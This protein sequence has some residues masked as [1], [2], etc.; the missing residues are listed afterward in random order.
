MSVL[1]KEW[2]IKNSSPNKTALEKVLENRDSLADG[3][4]EILHDPYLFEDMEFSVERINK[5]IKDKERIIVFGDYD[6]DG[7][8]GTAILVHVLGRLGAQ[9]SY[10]LPNRLED[11]YGFT[12]KFIPEF[13]DAGVSLLITTDC[14][15]SCADTITEAK[16]KG[17]ETIITDH[18]TVPEKFP[19]DAIAILH[20][21]SEKTAYPYRELTGAGV[22]L[23]L[24]QA[25]I[26]DLPEK[27]ELTASL[28]DL[29]TMGTIADLG[30]LTGE[31]RAIVK[32]GL[33]NLRTTSWVGIKKLMEIS[34]VPENSEIDAQTIGFRLAPR[35]NAA[36]RIGDPYVALSLILQEE[37]GEKLN[38]LGQK[39]ESL[40]VQ[41]QE[42]MQEAIDMVEIEL[43]GG[44]APFIVIKKDAKWHVGIIGLVAG[45]LVERY[46]K[47][48]IILQ[49]FGDELVASARSPE[50]FDMIEAITESKDLLISF[51][52]HAQAAG[53]NLK[54]ENYEEFCKKI[55]AYARK[56]LAGKAMKPR[57]KVDCVIG[58]DE[59]TMKLLKELDELKPFGIA[60]SRPMFVLKG[61]E[62]LFVNQVG[63][64]R[65]HLKFSLQLGNN[66]TEVIGFRLGSHVDEMRKHRKIDVVCHLDLNSWKNKNLLQLQVLDFRKSEQ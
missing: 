15:I 18:H 20:P 51:G 5:A 30:P 33:Q 2:I 40:N 14:G 57:L 53:F 58:K 48:A 63:R 62:P 13:V 65:S 7:I 32:K 10:R 59:V 4:E 36:G 46:G 25:L 1:G 21:K 12:E 39:L 23:K 8:T 55:S 47:P 49:D 22:A 35:I 44:E 38:L 52:G 66:R 16:Q 56:K 50:Y 28:I 34:A 27:D 3:G 42:M 29:A 31:N 37:K 24:A 54:K 45:R 60:S 11:G 43:A 41:R 26:K 17:I 19:H 64:E 61:V 9:V 6:V